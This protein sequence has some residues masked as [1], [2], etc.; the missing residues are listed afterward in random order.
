MMNNINQKIFN[1]RYKLVFWVLVSIRLYFNWTLPLMDKTEARYGEIARL[2]CETGNW[3]TPQIDY[4]IPFWGKPPLSIWASALS[5]SI[6]GPAEVFLR[7][8]HLIVFILVAFFIGK[9]RKDENQSMY[10]PGIIILTIPEFYIHAG[11]VST[12]AFLSIS[13]AIVMFGFWEALKENTKAYWGYLLFLGIGIGLLTKG[14]IILILTL[15]PIFIWALTTKNLKKVFIRIPWIVG[16]SIS[17]GISLPWYILAELST[18]GFIDYFIIGEHFDRYFNSK[19]E[20]DKYGFPKQQ[21][22]G[23]AWVFLVSFLLPWTIA[24]FQILIKKWNSIRQNSWMLFL[25]FWCAWTP[26]FFTSSKSLIHPYILPSCIPAALIISF[27]WTSLR[28]KKLYASIAIGLPILLFIVHISGAAKSF[29]NHTTDKYLISNL[30]KVK[31]MYVLDSKSY[32]SQF[33]TQ[34]KIQLI[35]I[36]QLKNV[37]VSQ[38]PFYIIISNNRFK[39]LNYSIKKKLRKIDSNKKTGIYEFDP[40][41]KN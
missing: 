9:Y 16:I 25:I 26:L 28:S 2:M 12:D 3:I 29:Y 40:S 34:G 6:F 7:L 31:K 11:V 32:S 39:L 33:Y 37:L 19:W 20:G 21:P 1:I 18:P 38:K 30:D 36:N 23:M 24:L 15:P 8:P 22:F 41:I 13:T 27:Y 35:K 4:G 17:L 14:P 10:L 5:I